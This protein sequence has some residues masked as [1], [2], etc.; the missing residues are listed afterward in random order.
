MPITVNSNPAAA[1]A[2]FYMSKNNSALQKSINRLSSGSKIV[3]PNDDAGGLAVSMKLESAVVRLK[4]AEKNIQNGISFLEVQDGVLANASKIMNRMIELKGLSQDV[5]KNSSDNDNY[6]REFRN[7]QV[8]LFE[9][10]N[11]T[12]NGVS[13]FANFNSEGTQE[14][15]FSDMNQSLALDNT[16]SIF[17]SSDG[18]TGPK[19]SINKALLLSALTIEADDLDQTDPTTFNEWTAVNA[20]NTAAARSTDQQFTFASTT[21]AGAM[22]LQEISVGVFTQALENLATLRADNGGTMSRLQ[23][24]S[25]NAQ[26]QAKNFAAANGRIVDVD[27]A[28]ESTNLAKYQILSQASASM[29]AQANSSMDMALMLLR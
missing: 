8:Q 17:T 1:S 3:H 9:M 2:N 12:F 28:A 23:Y 18:S 10:G 20:R 16:M 4:G 13:M 21:Y 24:A 11:L 19:V 27:I 5:L 15:I 26:L 29:I 25:D 22:D 14:A 7:L 6:N